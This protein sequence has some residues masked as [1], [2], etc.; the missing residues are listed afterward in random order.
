MGKVF[1][2]AGFL[3]S[4]KVHDYSASDLVRQYIGHTGPKV[5]QL[6]DKALG[7]VLLVDEAYRLREGQFAKDALNELIDCIIKERYRKRLI[8]I[9]AR[10]ENDVNALLAVNPGLI[11]RFS[12]VLNFNSLP[13]AD[14]FK[15]LGKKFLK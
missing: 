14:Y 3:A 1:Y 9:L 8:V 13:L 11:S 2:D 15:L 7:A 4:G 10:Y 12:E 6:L 5:R